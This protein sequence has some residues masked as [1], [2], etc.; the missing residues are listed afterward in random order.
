MDRLA[1][2][3]FTLCLSGLLIF[4]CDSE[5]SGEVGVQPSAESG[6]VVAELNQ[7]ITCLNQTANAAVEGHNRYLAWAGKAG[8]G[9]AGFAGAEAATTPL[10]RALLDACRKAL[11]RA[12]SDPQSVVTLWSRRGRKSSI[13][14][15]VNLL[16]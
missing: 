13:F 15:S 10:P 7:S 9:A 4:A 5:Q 3:M 12:P 6:L 11:K 1:L 8:P 14:S 2:W 16:K